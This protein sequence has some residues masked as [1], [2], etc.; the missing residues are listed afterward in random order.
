MTKID[1]SPGELAMNWLHRHLIL[2][3]LLI[4]AAVVGS[5]Y[6]IYSHA[7]APREI[8]L[9]QLTEAPAVGHLAPDFTLPTAAGD[10][11]TLND[12]RGRPVVLN[13]WAS[14]CGPCR[15]ETPHFQA[16]SEQYKNELIVIGVNQQESAATINAFATE[17]ELTYPLLIDEDNRVNQMYAVFG[18]PTTFFIDENGVIFDISP[19]AISLAILEDRI[20]RLIQ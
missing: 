4:A 5:L 15:I 17:F 19:G 13:F 8:D 12:L 11:L 14:W 9:T 18:L 10:I 1:S 16:F 3:I 6:I 2:W 20:A 7:V